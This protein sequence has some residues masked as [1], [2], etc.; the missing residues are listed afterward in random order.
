MRFKFVAIILTPRHDVRHADALAYLVTTIEV[1]SPRTVQ[2]DIQEEQSLHKILNK[3]SLYLSE[4][5]FTRS[6]YKVLFSINRVIKRKR[7]S[8]TQELLVEVTNLTR[9]DKQHQ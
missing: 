3:S 7:K 5:L 4:C 6:L 2:I 9:I 8:E 1:D